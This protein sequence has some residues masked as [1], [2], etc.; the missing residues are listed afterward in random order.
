[1]RQSA[2]TGALAENFPDRTR[3]IARAQRV[4]D[5]DGIG[6][7]TNVETERQRDRETE[8]QR[9]NAVSTFLRPSI[10][11]SLSLSVSPSLRPSV[12]P[13]LYP[14]GSYMPAISLRRQSLQPWRRVRRLINRNRLLTRA[15]LYLQKKS[16][17][18]L[19]LI[20]R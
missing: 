7:R 15:V 5:G 19:I 6:F 10:S 1:R 11:Q 14:C 18:L 4:R 3:R 20:G 2:P 12:P 16:R 17:E 9:D 8:R 13:S